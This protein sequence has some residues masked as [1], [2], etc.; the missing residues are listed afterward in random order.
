MSKKIVVGL[1]IIALIVIIIA[2]FRINGVDVFNDFARQLETES[3]RKLQMGQI[4]FEYNAESANIQVDDRVITI[5][6]NI[7]SLFI[8]NPFGDV[9]ITGE[10]RDDIVLSYKITVYAEEFEVAESLV[11]KLE[12]KSVRQGDRINFDMDAVEVSEGVY[13]IKRDYNLLVPED[14]YLEIINNNGNMEISDMISDVS[15]VDYKKEMKVKNINGSVEISKRQGSAIIEKVGE[16]N[17]DSAYNKVSI[18]HVNG[19]LDLD[20]AYGQADVS[21]VDGNAEIK[22]A[23]SS[24]E[25][26][27]ISGYLELEARYTQVKGDEIAGEFTGRISYGQLDLANVVNHVDVSARY[28]GISVAMSELLNDYQIYCEADNGNINTNLDLSV[29]KEDNRSI[30][31]GRTGT[32][33]TNINVISNYADVN[34]Y[35]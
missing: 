1:I 12:I 26:E 32:G 23:Y 29:K 3:L 21:S 31:E 11:E 4:D 24:V 13:G 28:T 7:D 14:L 35:Q 19:D 34:V 20:Q 6:D 18:N 33:S 9:I 15:L 27:K 5:D 17:M 10:N 8:R 25:V 30:M 16:L 2:D 22:A